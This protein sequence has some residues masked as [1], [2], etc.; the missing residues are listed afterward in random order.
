MENPRLQI[1]GLLSQLAPLQYQPI[2]IEQQLAI[3]H[4][5][6]ESRAESHEQGTTTSAAR[7]TRSDTQLTSFA[8]PLQA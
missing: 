5:R 4:L 3:A 8:Q 1:L 7:A 6:P 2:A